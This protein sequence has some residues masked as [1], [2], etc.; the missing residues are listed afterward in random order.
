[1]K[2]QHFP[3]RY[4]PAVLF[5][6]CVICGC[7]TFSSHKGSPN[8]VSIEGTK[9]AWFLAL[10]GRR[11]DI[12]GVG[13]GRRQSREGSVDFLKMAADLGANTVRTWGVNQ[14]DR[15]YLDQAH[16]YGLYVD[17]GVWLNPSR[18]GYDVSYRNKNYC[19]KVRKQTLRYVKRF[20][21]HPAVLLWNIGNE[22]IYWTESE[23]ERIAFARFLETLIRDIHAVDPDHPVIYTT[24][25]TTALPYIKKY[26]PSLD[27][28]GVNVYG[29]IKFAHEKIIDALDIPYLVTE[30]GPPGNWDQPKDRFGKP[31]ELTDESQVYFYKRHTREIEALNGYCLGA[32]VFHLGDTT[33]VSATWWNINYKQYLKPSFWAMKEMYTGAKSEH[34]LPLVRSLTIS[35][36]AGLKPKEKFSIAPK[37]AKAYDGKLSFKYFYST[38]SEDV[39]LVEFPN[40]EWP[41]EVEGEGAE[42]TARAPGRAGLYR[43]YVLAYDD[44]GN[45]STL[46]RVIEVVNP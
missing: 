23:Q 43:I 16:R 18:K 10:N 5:F 3:F 1:M 42:V 29:G 14:G 15:T 39:G 13:V 45:G 38:A 44:Y 7:S 37:L 9:G 41:I 8:Q 24:S 46:S 17:A 19:A 20:K 40:N 35:K 11:F 4:L 2:N 21:D 36:T 22:T 27:I 30:Y 34:P 25:F 6:L 28:L 26:V 33:Q 32:F 31:V 12:K